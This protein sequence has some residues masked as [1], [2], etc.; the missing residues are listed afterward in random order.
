MILLVGKIMYIKGLTLDK[1]W[2]NAVF[3]R[4]VPFLQV[5][6]RDVIER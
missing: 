2:V 5:E 6:N 3:G 4:V 1:N